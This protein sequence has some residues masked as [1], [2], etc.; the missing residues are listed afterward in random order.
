MGKIKS[1]AVKMA[2][3][4][5]KE[6]KIPFKNSFEENKEILEGTMPYKKIRNQLA[7]YLTR[8]KKMDDIEQENLLRKAK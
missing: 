5:L 8:I 7:G 2:A 1:K 3:K 6:H 4:R